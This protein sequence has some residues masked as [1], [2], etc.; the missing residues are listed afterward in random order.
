MKAVE[1]QTHIFSWAVG[2]P[3]VGIR[4]VPHARIVTFKLAGKVYVMCRYAGSYLMDMADIV[5]M[6]RV[7]N[8]SVHRGAHTFSLILGQVQPNARILNFDP[9]QDAPENIITMF[10]PV[11]Q[12]QPVKVFNAKGR[13]VTGEF[14]PNKYGRSDSY[15]PDTGE[16]NSGPEGETYEHTWKPGEGVKTRRVKRT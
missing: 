6:R 8:V 11:H 7:L 15:D 13:D 9:R 1:L 5:L 16:W 3:V 4:H 14:G 12:S 10:V 2:R